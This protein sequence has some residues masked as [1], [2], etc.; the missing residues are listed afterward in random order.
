MGKVLT[1]NLFLDIK[2][3]EG[4]PPINFYDVGILGYVDKPAIQNGFFI[5]VPMM[6][7]SLNIVRT[8]PILKF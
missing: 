6:K 5:S 4:D 2:N 7:I 8:K 1:G 3:I